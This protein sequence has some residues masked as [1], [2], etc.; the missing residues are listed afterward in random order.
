[1]LS[2]L[3]MSLSFYTEGTT[4]ACMHACEMCYFNIWRGKIYH[5]ISDKQGCTGDITLED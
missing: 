4:R 1:M 3:R 5:I 2:D